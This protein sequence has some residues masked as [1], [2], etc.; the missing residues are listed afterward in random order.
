MLNKF[1]NSEPEYI[2]KKTNIPVFK[3]QDDDLYEFSIQNAAEIHDNA[4]RWLFETHN[5]NEENLRKNLIDR[6]DLKEGNTVL[7]TATGAG[8]DIKY[9]LDKTDFKII[10]IQ[11]NKV[12]GGSFALTVA[13]K[14]SAHKEENKMVSW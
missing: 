10:D 2:D 5:I 4:L 6:L 1:Y 8:N 11:L 7:M 9:I 14:K 13:K 3:N 12:N